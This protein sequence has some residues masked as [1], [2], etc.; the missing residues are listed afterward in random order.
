[1]LLCRGA[2]G[3][4]STR[5]AEPLLLVFP[6]RLP[7]LLFA[8]MS[9]YSQV[10]RFGFGLFSSCPLGVEMNTS[11]K[12][13]D[14]RPVIEAEGATGGPCGP[15][16]GERSRGGVCCLPLSTAAV[17]V[18]RYTVLRLM[19]RQRLEEMAETPATI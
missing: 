3:L 10:V 17:P 1:M 6:F 8:R 19:I 5:L 15:G 14:G 12:V 7:I 9:N 18:P 4:V 2:L 16:G 13:A 11:H